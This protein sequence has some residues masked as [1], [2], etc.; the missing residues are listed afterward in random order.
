MAGAGQI[1]NL[2][3]VYDAKGVREELSD[4]IS[5]VSPTDTPLLSNTGSQPTSNTFFEWQTDALGAAAQNHQIDGFD[6]TTYS[7]VT[8]TVRMGNYT[9]ISEKDFAV[10]GTENVVNKAGRG[11]EVGYLATKAAKELKR[12]QETNYLANNAAV[13]GT[14]STARETGGLAAFLKTNTDKTATNGADPVWTSA[15]T[16]ARSDGTE[17]TWTETILKSAVLKA[18]NSGGDPSMIMVGPYLKQVT[19]AFA[20]IAAQRFMAPGSKGTTIIGAA[21]MYMSDFGMLAIVPNRFQPPHYAYVIDLDQIRRRTLRG[22]Q[23][24]T[25]AK[26]GDSEK[27]MILVEEGLQVD[28]EKAHAIAAD[29][30]SA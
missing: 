20:G 16:G 21:D 15:P 10:S 12:D 22:Y 19:S 27:R 11:A 18:Y 1:T 23:V 13:A 14:S 8:A 24:H 29:L 17:R 3:D 7:A 30:T 4:L 26:T 6:I 28:N 9:S 5:N 25:M 2:Y